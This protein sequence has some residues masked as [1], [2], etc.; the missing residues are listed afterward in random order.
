MAASSITVESIE[1][2]SDTEWVF[3]EIIEDPTV[4]WTL[5]SINFTG[6]NPASNPG[7]SGTNIPCDGTFTETFPTASNTICVV[8]GAGGG[9]SEFSMT[10]VGVSKFLYGYEYLSSGGYQGMTLSFGTLV[11]LPTI[12]GF[13]PQIGPVGTEVVITGTNFSAQPSNNFVTINGIPVPVIASTQTKS[14]V[15]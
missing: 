14:Q 1:T 2:L 3:F 12:T 6:A 13:S 8:D 10:A 15:G 11:L 7:F 4:T 9:Y 5:N